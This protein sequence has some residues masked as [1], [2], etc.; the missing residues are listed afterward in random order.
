MGLGPMENRD[1]LKEPLE[2]QLHPVESETK[3]EK[4]LKKKKTKISEIIKGLLPWKK[5]REEKKAK[6][7]LKEEARERER[8]ECLKFL[9]PKKAEPAGRPGSEW[10]EKNA[11]VMEELKHRT[12]ATP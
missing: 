9:T 3:E 10:Q 8:E 4:D 11:A 1:E 6:K 12:V 2:K 7:M 5:H